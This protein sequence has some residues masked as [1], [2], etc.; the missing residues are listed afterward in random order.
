MSDK[1]KAAVVGLWGHAFYAEAI[2]AHPDVELVAVCDWDKTENTSRL[3]LFAGQYGA[4]FCHSIDE[5]TKFGP[6]GAIGI[7]AP[8]A[9]VPEIFSR[10]AAVTKGVILEKPVAKDM[11][12]ARLIAETA[13]KYKSIVSMAYPTRN[14]HRLQ[15][16]K[17]IINGSEIGRPLSGTYTYLQTGGP[18]FT[19]KT[20][21]E[22]LELI[23]G[24]DDTMFLGYGVLDFKWLAGSEI[25]TVFA[26]G[27]AY[28]YENYKDAG[29]N[30]LAHINFSMKNGFCGSITV[31]RISAKNRP[32]IHTMEINGS[33]GSCNIDFA[34]EKMN[35]STS[36]GF[37][38]IKGV[39]TCTP[40]V[41]LVDDFINSVLNRKQCQYDY[42]DA[43][44]T[45]AVQ[46][47]VK[48]SIR[49]GK[50]EIVME[51]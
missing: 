43:F 21:K 41:R 44:H 12:G 31:G 7:L 20:D 48:K 34:K 35:L 17:E 29:I 37:N 10:L 27:N 4:K 22:N 28:F 18:M 46:E 38:A 1:I 39:S 40:T 5:I 24:G 13:E 23:A 50:T 47:A 16:V 49:S 32:A 8:P 3:E 33:R 51:I 14:H 2:A 45:I 25:A 30:D 42:R 6:F 36:E 19:V 26:R 15:V 11:T 9:K